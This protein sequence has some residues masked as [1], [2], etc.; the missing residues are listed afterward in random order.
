LLTRNSPL[1]DETASVVALP[2]YLNGSAALKNDFT[3]SS[4]PAIRTEIE[5]I[6]S[7]QGHTSFETNRP[8]RAHGHRLIK[9]LPA[10]AL[11]EAARRLTGNIAGPHG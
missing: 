3:G 1:L 8:K 6:S 7:A 11:A 2:G 5:S 4:G 10:L 9:K